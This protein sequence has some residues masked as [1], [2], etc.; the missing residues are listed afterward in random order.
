ML[1]VDTEALP[2]RA[3]ED[4]VKRLIWGEHACGTAG[5][6]EMCQIGDEMGI[7]H[8]FFVDVCAAHAYEKQIA[9][10]VC[11][12]DNA[13]QDVQLHAHP[14]YLPADYWEQHGFTYRPRFLNQYDQ[15]KAEFTL[16]HFGKFIS[17]LTGKAILAFRAGSFRWNANTIRALHTAGIR[18]S[19][20]NSMKAYIDG[21]CPYGVPTNAPFSWSNDVIEV[22]V[23]ERLS[24][25]R[26]ERFGW[27]RLSHPYSNQYFT[28]PWRKLWPFTFGIDKSF[29]VLLMH[30]WSLLYWDENDHAQ[31]RDDRRIDSYRK[32]VRKLAKD[33]DIITTPDFLDLYSRGK[34]K[35]TH[36][37]DL[38][39]T[40]LRV[41]D[42]RGKVI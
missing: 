14:E 22:P 33:Y 1:T 2:R 13:G 10:V 4:H 27:E 24:L 34:I 6:R 19:F 11:W 35:T 41:P 9:E 26:C 7:R 38:A 40:E 32:I 23:T 39:L 31:Y 42:R 17:N 3:A 30:S 16:K 29:L 37:V 20:N 15:P 5:V 25:P 28:P 36:S 21:V 12:L 18:L 8:V